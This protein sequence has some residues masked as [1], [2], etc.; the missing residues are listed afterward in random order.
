MRLRK[1][2]FLEHHFCFVSVGGSYYVVMLPNHPSDEKEAAVQFVQGN[3]YTLTR[4]YI[5]MLYIETGVMSDSR[6]P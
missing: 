4:Q 6:G 2:V 5:K 1:R 3:A